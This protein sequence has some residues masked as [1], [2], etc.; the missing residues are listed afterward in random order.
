[1]RSDSTY[2]RTLA[3]RICAGVAEGN[4]LNT[5]CRKLG[6]PRQRVQGWL[7]R[8]QEFSQEYA[9]ACEVRL[10]IMEDRLAELCEQAH[11]AALEEQTGRLRLDAIRLE[12]DTLK[13]QL[14]KLMPAK[15]GDK[16]RM[17]L[18][19]RDGENL[20]PTHTREEDLAYLTMLAAVQAKTPPPHQA[21]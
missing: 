20:L 17:E 10:C 9:A 18:T 6:I 1:M 2:T 12:I 13:W 16:T 8:Y 3:A 4:G 15:Y 21:S 7:A 11:Q 19:G 5:I 14:A